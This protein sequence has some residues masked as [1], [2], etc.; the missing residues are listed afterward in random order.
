[1]DCT[2]LGRHGRKIAVNSVDDGLDRIDGVG[3]RLAGV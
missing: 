2:K 1:M 3:F